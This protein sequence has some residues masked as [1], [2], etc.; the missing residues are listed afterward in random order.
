MRSATPVQK[1]CSRG[2]GVGN[3]EDQVGVRA[4]IE[5]AHAQPAQRDHH[6]L[7]EGRV[8]GIR[9]RRAPPPARCGRPRRSRYR[10]AP[11]CC[12]ASRRWAR[13]GECSRSGCAASAGGRSGAARRRPGSGSSI[14]SKGWPISSSSSGI[15]QQVVGEVGAVLEDVEHCGGELRIRLQAAQQLGAGKCLFQ[16]MLEALAAA[17]QARAATASASCGA[18]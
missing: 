18:R 7:I 15:A 10:P 6:H 3:H 14:N 13:R 4:Q 12:S 5:F 1:A 16:K 11:R 9:G 2:I 8:G 17:M